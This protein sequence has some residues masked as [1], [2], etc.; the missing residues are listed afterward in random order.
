MFRVVYNELPQSTQAEIDAGLTPQDNLFPS[1][2]LFPQA[3][4]EGF[5]NGIFS[6]D[7]GYPSIN[8]DK[9]EYLNRFNKD[10]IFD[11]LQDDFSG[12]NGTA[13]IIL[14]S[15]LSVWDTPYPAD[16]FDQGQYK[17]MIDAMTLTLDWG[18]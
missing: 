6:F 18:A 2:T 13:T 11:G 8:F 16:S 7:E 1:D 4:E 5:E 12:G 3:L 15:V 10:L 14:T 9:T 17:D